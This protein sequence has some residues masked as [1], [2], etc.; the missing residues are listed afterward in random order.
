MRWKGISIGIAHIPNTGMKVR[1]PLLMENEKSINPLVFVG[2]PYFPY[3]K[4]ENSPWAASKSSLRVVFCSLLE[5][6]ASG[7]VA[8]SPW[9]SHCLSLPVHVHSPQPRPH[10]QLPTCP[11]WEQGI[12]PASGRVLLLLLSFCARVFHSNLWKCNQTLARVVLY[13]APFPL[14]SSISGRNYTECCEQAGVSDCAKSTALVCC[15]HKTQPHLTEAVWSCCLLWRMLQSPLFHIF[16]ITAY[17]EWYI[18]LHICMMLVTSPAWSDRWSFKKVHLLNVKIILF[19]FKN[20]QFHRS[21]FSSSCALFFFPL[22]FF[23]VGKGLSTRTNWPA[24]MNNKTSYSKN[25]LHEWSFRVLQSNCPFSKATSYF[26][27]SWRKFLG[28]VLLYMSP[29]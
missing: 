17:I 19:S 24:C 1:H 23:P 7:L 9:G 21:I 25:V 20:S 12:S 11:S 22:F 15:F 28:W 29:A 26:L 3:W 18:P 6:W 13:S 16:H 5:G 27:K 2:W 4:E 14:I 8:E 10:S